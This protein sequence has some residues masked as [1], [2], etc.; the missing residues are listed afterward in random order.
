MK[1]YEIK[2]YPFETLRQTAAGLDVATIRTDQFQ[3]MA[4]KLMA[5]LEKEFPLGAG[6]SA[7]Q[8]GIL[9]RVFAINLEIDGGGFLKQ[10]FINPRIVT[11]SSDKTIDWEGCLSFPDQWGK[12]RRSRSIQ[13][14]ALDLEGNL[15]TTQASQFYARLIQHEIDHLDG[16][17]FIDKLESPIVNTTELNH[18][19]EQEIVHDKKKSDHPTDLQA[20]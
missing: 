16:I 15:F 8:I 20:A 6:L 14:E 13:V 17:L 9:Q 11:A 7:N 1:T 5:T 10:I 4:K 19:I 18:I 12:V 2:K 3:N